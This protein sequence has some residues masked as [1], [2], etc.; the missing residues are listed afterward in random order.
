MITDKQFITYF[1]KLINFYGDGKKDIP[2]YTIAYFIRFEYQLKKIKKK[3]CCLYYAHLLKYMLQIQ[4]CTDVKLNYQISDNIL[5]FF[6]Q[7]YNNK[8]V[9]LYKKNGMGNALYIE[10]NKKY[11]L[12]NLHHFV[13]D[14]ESFVPCKC[15]AY[16]PK[17]EQCPKINCDP[18]NTDTTLIETI[19]TWNN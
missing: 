18:Y 15:S 2:H 13:Q 6:E 11:N 8:N 5:S 10:L 19:L 3:E 9:I 1:T 4:G 14:G 7:Q 12:F 16:R 17:S